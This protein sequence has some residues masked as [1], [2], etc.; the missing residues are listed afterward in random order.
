MSGCPGSGSGF[1]R[2]SSVLVGASPRG[3]ILRRG[4]RVSRL[5]GPILVLWEDR[6]RVRAGCARRLP[7]DSAV[8]V[9]PMRGWQRNDPPGAPFSAP[10]GRRG[11][12]RDG[13]APPNRLP[14]GRR[15]TR[16]TA[17]T[18]PRSTP[19]DPARKAHHAPWERTTTSS[20]GK[21]R[22]HPL[23]N[24]QDWEN[25]PHRLQASPEELRTNNR[26]SRDALIQRNSSGPNIRSASSA[27]RPMG[28]PVP[29][30]HPRWRMPLYCPH[31]GGAPRG[32][33]GA[34]ADT[35]EAAQRGARLGREGAL[36]S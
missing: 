23:N 36:G 11:A 2:R 10:V 15:T 14:P 4:R 34:P 1:S 17:P 9:G 6:S 26:S 33:R 7:H 31:D 28:S 18:P 20:P 27:L 16:T 29:C 3:R 24:I 5:P 19:G 21:A 35:G 30:A 8:L 13:A 32:R 12:T 25:L 22:R